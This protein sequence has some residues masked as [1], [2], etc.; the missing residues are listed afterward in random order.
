V[1]ECKILVA[2]KWAGIE[3]YII[4]IKIFT[5]CATVVATMFPVV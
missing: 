2:K 4:I 1:S 5:V 3:N